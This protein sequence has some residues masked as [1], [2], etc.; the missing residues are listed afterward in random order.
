M[1]QQLLGRERPAV[2]QTTPPHSLT[3]S[4]TLQLGCDFLNNRLRLGMEGSCDQSAAEKEEQAEQGFLL[5]L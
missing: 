4:A 5:C 3:G 2:N 1:T